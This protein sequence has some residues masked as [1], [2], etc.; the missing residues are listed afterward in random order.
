MTIKIFFKK[1]P[2]L[3]VY[4]FNQD[5]KQVTKK[6]LDIQKLVNF[7]GSFFNVQFV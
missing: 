6:I 4:I 7:N 2:N 1:Y 3:L 5:F